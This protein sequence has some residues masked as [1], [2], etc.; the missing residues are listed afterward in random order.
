MTA[1]GSGD[2]PPTR[3]EVTFSRCSSPRTHRPRD[4]DRSEQAAGRLGT[5]FAAAD[6]NLLVFHSPKSDPSIDPSALKSP[7]HHAATC[8]N[9]L[10]FQVPKSVPSTSP[11]RFAS[12]LRYAAPDGKFSAS[13]RVGQPLVQIVAVDHSVT[14]EVKH[15]TVVPRGNVHSQGVDIET[16]KFP[17]PLKSAETPDPTRFRTSWFP[18]TTER[19]KPL[20]V[21]VSVKPQ[22]AD[23]IRGQ[24]REV[25]RDGRLKPFTSEMSTT[26]ANE[27]EPPT[28]T[29]SNSPESRPSISI[30][31]VAS[32][33]WLQSPV[34]AIDPTPS[35]GASVRPVFTT[36]ASRVPRPGHHSAGEWFHRTGRHGAVTAERA[37]VHDR[38]ASGLR[39]ARD[40]QG[41]SRLHFQGHRPGVGHDRGEFD[42]RVGRDLRDL[43]ATRTVVQTG[44]VQVDCG[45][46]VATSCVLAFRQLPAVPKSG[47]AAGRPL[48]RVVQYGVS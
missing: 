33:D 18:P 3:A 8:E 34:M 29:V 27:A 45:A 11:S 5:A 38:Y 16:M 22:V 9:L 23:R 17:S 48:I 4:E 36:S 10:A 43:A 14:R 39:R 15:G 1:A 42:R 32:D 7:W 30:A 40:V 37:A 26:P 41:D 24:D 46:V 28:D 44:L 6:V 2:P 31:K 47:A 13:R 19:L 35:P 12:P 21:P 25:R 20:V